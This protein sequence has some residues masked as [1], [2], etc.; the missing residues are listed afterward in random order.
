MEEPVRIGKI[1]SINYAAGMARVAYSDRDGAVTREIPFLSS[2]YSMPEIG[3]QVLV[4]HLSNGAEAAVILGT[5]W[6]DQVVPPEGKKGVF[7]K[8]L[9]P[10]AGECFIRYDASSKTLDIHCDG[11]I[12]INGQTVHINE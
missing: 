8:D 3:A 4:L 1:S 2:E 10:T 9:A 11:R 12:N 7:R 5:P 6:S